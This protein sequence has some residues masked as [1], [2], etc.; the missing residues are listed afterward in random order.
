MN[1]VAALSSF[2]YL[3]LDPR[4]ACA[5]I[6][7]STLSSSSSSYNGRRLKRGADTC[8]WGLGAITS[9]VVTGATIQLEI[10]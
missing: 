3:F 5:A 4:G 7:L 2:I 10:I 9:T 8:T 6:S 1:T